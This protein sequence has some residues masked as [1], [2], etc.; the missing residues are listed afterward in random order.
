MPALTAAAH[1][2]IKTARYGPPHDLF[3]VLGFAAFRLYAAAA[4]RASLR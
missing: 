3:L 2:N 1:F 4:M